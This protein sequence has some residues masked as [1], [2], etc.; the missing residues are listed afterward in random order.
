M[1]I[2]SQV[3]VGISDLLY[4]GSMLNKKKLGLVL[5]L[6]FSDV[7]YASHLLVLGALTG[8]II[9]FI[10]AAF[11]LVTY[12]LEKFNKQKYVKYAVI[13]TCVATIVTTI[14][15]WVGA[16]SLLPMF[17]MLVY[18]FGMVFNNVVF[19]KGGALLRNLLNIIYLI[20][21]TSYV[22]AILEFGLMVS[23]IV[24]IIINIK[25]KDKEKEITK[26]AE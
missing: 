20:L 23:A 12:L 17:S 13:V 3:L 24:G 19:V 22:G 15:T 1:Y 2:F 9:I 8:S 25:K 14:F 4:V 11:L 5:F 18:L 6:F 7:L 16:I 21:I 26:T 10:D